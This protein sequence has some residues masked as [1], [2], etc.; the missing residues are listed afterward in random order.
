VVLFIMVG[1]NASKFGG[2]GD[3]TGD[4][5]MDFFSIRKKITTKWAPPTEK[6]WMS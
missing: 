4:A 1:M 5:A 3:I 6:N 2:E